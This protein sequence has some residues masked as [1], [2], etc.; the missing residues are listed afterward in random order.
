[1][2][3]EDVK[4]IVIKPMVDTPQG[5]Y[6]LDEGKGLSFVNMCSQ[7]KK[8]ISMEDT[9]RLIINC[10]VSIKEMETDKDPRMRAAAEKCKAAS[11]EGEAELQKY[12]RA[13]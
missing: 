10:R 6:A 8:I 9:K 11:A 5:Q 13:S 12:R 3:R 7:K 1:M 4:Q 2:T